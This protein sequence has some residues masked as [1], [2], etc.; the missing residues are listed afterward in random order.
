MLQN[1]NTLKQKFETGK[2]PTQQDFHDL[3]D[4]FVLQQLGVQFVTTGD[5]LT[6]PTGNKRLLALQAGTYNNLK[7]SGGGAA[8]AITVTSGEMTSSFVYLDYNFSTNAWAKNLTSMSME[9][10]GVI[11]LFAGV[12]APPGWAFCHGQELSISQYPA[13]FAQLG[14][15]YGGDGVTSFALPDLRGRVPVGAGSGPGLP[16]VLHGEKGGEAAHTLLQAELPTHSHALAVSNANAS[17]SAPEQG[18]AIATPGFMSGREF[19]PTLGYNSAPPNTI[20][21]QQSVG[22]TGDSEPHNNMQPFLGLNFIICTHG[23]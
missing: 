5:V 21:N 11:K 10:V 4:S 7:L 13:L 23:Y 9:Y 18:N 3:I 2:R 14:T 15:A 16:Q 20:L 17:V 22:S 1:I 19:I 6:A 12:T 8:P